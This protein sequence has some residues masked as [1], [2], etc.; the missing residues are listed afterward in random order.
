MHNGAKLKQFEALSVCGL[1]LAVCTSKLPWMCALCVRGVC[2][3]GFT[4]GCTWRPRS[5]QRL[6]FICVLP[7]AANYTQHSG[8]AAKLLSRARLC[9]SIISSPAAQTCC[10]ATR[11]ADIQT[12]ATELCESAQLETLDFAPFFPQ[13]TLSAQFSSASK[14]NCQFLELNFTIG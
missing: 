3:S 4:A 13:E 8:S 12:T 7:A 5:F 6:Q 11:S 9:K 1:C 10:P 14:P 2:R